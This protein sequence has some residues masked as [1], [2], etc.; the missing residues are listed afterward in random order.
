MILNAGKQ[1]TE[2]SKIVC[3]QSGKELMTGSIEAAARVFALQPAFVGQADEGDARVVLI[4][5]PGDE[6]SFFQALERA[7]HGGW[8]YAGALGQI[9]LVEFTV[10]MKLYQN[11]NLSAADAGFFQKRCAQLEMLSGEPDNLPDKLDLLVAGLRIIRLPIVCLL[12]VR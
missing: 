12:T 8:G 4:C 9:T 10:F 11:G 3:I 2:L 7:A 6:A 1:S 5:C